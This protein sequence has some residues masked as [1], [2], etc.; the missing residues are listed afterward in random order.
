MWHLNII[1]VS[2]KFQNKLDQLEGYNN[3]QETVN[4]IKNDLLKFLIDKKSINK[5]VVA[6]GAAAK[7]NTFLNYAGIKIDL[8][9]AVYDIA[10]SKQGKY[11][12]GSHIPIYEPNALL[13]EPLDYVV[14]LPWN[15]ADEV[16][17]QNQELKNTGV[18]FLT[19]VPELRC[20]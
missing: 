16:V 12:P 14:I 1:L 9:P 4:K 19:A 8:I 5:L 13:N 3:F 6:Y 15:I 11:L 2:V 17:K 20:S 10:E 18:L 7:G